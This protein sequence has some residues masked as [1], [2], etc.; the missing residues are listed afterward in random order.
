MEKDNIFKDIWKMLHSMK[1]GI[2][3]LII[4][5]IS[6]IAG[7]LI[8]Q[9]NII[10][11]YQST[12][13][14]GFFKI[15]KTLSLHKVYSSWW[16]ILMILILSI[17]LIL[18]SIKRFPTIL[19][20]MKKQPNLERE[21]D[22]QG[23]LFRGTIDKE[24]HIDEI[25]N[26]SRFKKVEKIENQEGV[27]YFGK[28][29]SLG[30]L[31]SWITHVGLLIIILAYVFGKILG[32]EV[33][34]HGVPGST[35]NI[36]GTDYLVDIE[37]FHIEFREDHTVSQY[38]SQI[39]VRDME[40]SYSQKGNVR[41]NHPFRAEK[42]NIYQNGTGWAVDV[43]LKKNNEDF[44]SRTLYQSEVYVE[45]NKNIALQF[46]NFYPHYDDSHGHPRTLTPYL[47][48]PKLVYAIFYEGHMVAMNVV[49]MGDEII[50]EEYSFAIGNPQMFTL[51]QIGHDP[52]MKGA[53][54]GGIILLLGIFLA[55]YIDPKE[56]RVFKYK[57]GRV[58]IWGNSHK[59][60]GVFMDE[61]NIILQEI[62]EGEI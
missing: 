8:P 61:M 57:D 52:G 39:Q 55:F 22:G 33:F 59:N 41:V 12:Y 46:I 37:D 11:F 3:L 51:L 1:F 31:G 30:Y 48:N 7:T 20:M 34:V 25:F 27:F 56:L 14:P 38:I 40:G 4:I 32:F 36:E 29:A 44:S 9:D 10:G 43:N 60:Q 62:L 21:L 49:D 45:D 18:C 28:K 19:K 35:H 17:N 16:F 50:W 53:A 58:E 6:S 23:L 24:I 42:M 54:I 15:I 5:G 47:K 13:S 26:K 2:I